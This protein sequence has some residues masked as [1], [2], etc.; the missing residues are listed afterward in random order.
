[1]LHC[2]DLNNGDSGGK[3]YPRRDRICLRTWKMD[4]IETR[5]GARSLKAGGD[6]I[7]RGTK[8]LAPIR[9]K[10]TSLEVLG[11]REMRDQ[12]MESE[13]LQYNRT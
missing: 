4:R 6:C 9:K 12:S 1:M 13:R 7:I 11:H 2:V 3:L 8:G 10:I 5:R